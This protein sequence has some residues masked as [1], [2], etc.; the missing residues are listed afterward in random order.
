V[1]DR[2]RPDRPEDVARPDGPEHSVSAPLE[3]SGTVPRGAPPTP[4]LATATV[5]GTV[6][7]HGEDLVLVTA[8]IDGVLRRHRR[9]Y[10]RGWPS[11][12]PSWPVDGPRQPARRWLDEARVLLAD[13]Q[14]FGRAAVVAW[15]L[16]DDA[17]AHE[18]VSSG[19]L[20]GLADEMTPSLAEHLSPAGVELLRRRA[21]LVALQ[22]GLLEASVA[23]PVDPDLSERPSGTISAPQAS[24]LRVGNLIFGREALSPEV[25]VSLPGRE[26]RGGRERP[27][28][29][30]TRSRSRDGPTPGSR[31]RG[32]CSAGRS[33][34]SR[35]PGRRGCC[36]APRRWGSSRR[37]SSGSRGHTPHPR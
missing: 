9:D 13:E 28:A 24:R 21:P 14:V 29:R 6:A 37:R 25:E 11:R 17:V 34:P 30:G 2:Q 27:T 5:G 33:C 3:S 1:A 19:V 22:E 7:D 15:S 23:L 36:R 10:L 35:G 31:S 32:R 20:G 16:L 8:L 12:A 18:A 4:E 26:R